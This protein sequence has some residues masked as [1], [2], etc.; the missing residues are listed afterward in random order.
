MQVFWAIKFV[1]SN[2]I[3]IP[4]LSN[5][6]QV[7]KF[8]MQV[9]KLKCLE[10]FGHSCWSFVGSCKNGLEIICLLL[11]FWLTSSIFDQRAC[12]LGQVCR[13]F[14][15][16]FVV[17]CWDPCKI[18]ILARFTKKYFQSRSQAPHDRE[19]CSDN[20]NGYISYVCNM[21]LL[22]YLKSKPW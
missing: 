14:Y 8:P 1:F 20:Y 6:V 4:S 5:K 16:D 11:I 15:H 21:L 9:L 12:H 17:A 3:L 2:T 18:L 10:T 13:F 19:L 22:R 7:L